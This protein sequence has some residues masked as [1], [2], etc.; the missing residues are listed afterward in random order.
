MNKILSTSL[1]ISFLALTGCATGYKTTIAPEFKSSQKDV[2]LASFI[3]QKEMDARAPLANSAGVGAQFGLIGA[4]VSVAIDSS[5]NQTNIENKEV[6]IAPLRDALIDYDFNT[7]FHQE[8]TNKIA[9]IDWINVTNQTEVN[10]QNE[11]ELKDGYF[12][13]VDTSYSLSSDFTTLQVFTNVS[14]NNVTN[15]KDKK[16]GKPKQKVET[17]F[18]NLYKYSS[19]SLERL[20]KTKEEY[21]AQVAEVEA[22]YEARL[23]KLE[24]NKSKGDLRAA[25]KRKMRNIK[26]EYSFAEGN[27][28]MA[29]LWAKDE[30]ALA[31]QHLN[32]S[33]FEI[34]KMI[35][36]DL[37]D[38]KTIDEYKKD[39][40]IQTY[41]DGLQV[42]SEGAQRVIVRDI[43]TAMA[44]QLCSLKKGDSGNHCKFKL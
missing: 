32:E 1:A 36:L 10:D 33:A 21:D 39:K 31:K 12:L 35:L 2:H 34:S 41:E 43:Q 5:V 38:T 22:W 16:T 23:A 20:T 37:S 11:I 8:V 44:G 42:V 6:Q 29:E 14:L 26:E 18:Q 15:E 19:P 25:K 40:S 13:K 3:A 17:L 7:P 28:K 4:L 30:A 27:L 9:K 24:K